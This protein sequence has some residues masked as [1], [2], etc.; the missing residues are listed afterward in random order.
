VTYDPFLLPGMAEG[1][2]TV[3]RH[4]SE[5]KKICVYGD[6]DVDGLLAVTLLTEFFGNLP[7]ASKDRIGWY[8]PSRFGEGY[9][10]N[11]GA[12]EQIRADGADLIVTV[13]C[14]VVSAREADMAMK[15][16]MA[17]VITDHHEPDPAVLPVCPVIDPKMPGAAY[18]FTGLCGCGVAFKL[19][20]AMRTRYYPDDEGAR[21]AL[22]ATL[23]LVAVATIADM[24]P[25]ADEN[26]TLVKYGMKTLNAGTRWQLAELAEGVG[27]K[28]GEITARGVAFGVAPHLN[29]AG[30][31]GD[32]ALAVDLFRTDDRAAA[33]EVIAELVERN[34]ERRREQD[35]T[36]RACVEIIDGEYPDANFLFVRP[37]RAHEGVAG[38][39]AGNIKERYYRPVAVL[40]ETEEGGERVLRGSARSVAGLDITA[41]IR[42]HAGLLVRYGGHA[43]AAGFTLRPENEEALREALEADVKALASDDPGLFSPPPVCDA[44]ILPEEASL[45]LARM[46]EDFEPTGVGNPRPVLLVRDR[47]PGNVRRMGAENQH[48]RFTADGLDCVLFARGGG[49][50]DLPEGPGPFDLYGS[51]EVNRWKERENV[52]FI[53]RQVVQ[54]RCSE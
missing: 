10:L 27:L 12:I 17:V 16:G 11:E 15:A 45:E 6:Y 20:Q 53:V 22:N 2:E 24:T 31:M 36:F 33:K 3:Y 4:I 21:A 34:A 14:G 40:A 35:E 37:S 54:S 52:R 19:A 38:I 47:T 42:A 46:L 5:G 1:I 32:A 29:A 9:G 39:V 51:L 30:R 7:G 43:M 49:T 18:P 50:A 13:D 26:R 23:D 48:L 28:A 44:E 41:L 25:L 8:I